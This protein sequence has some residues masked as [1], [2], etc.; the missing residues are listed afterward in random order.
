LAKSK[1]GK[2]DESVIEKRIQDAL[3]AQEIKLEEQAKTNQKSLIDEL[4]KIQ[5]DISEKD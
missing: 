1:E 4:K 2:V 3:K 5:E